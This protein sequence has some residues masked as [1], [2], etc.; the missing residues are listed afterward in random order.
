VDLGGGLQSR[1]AKQLKILSAPTAVAIHFVRRLKMGWNKYCDD[2][3]CPHF[4]GGN[5]NSE[6]CALGFILKFRTPKSYSDI[7]TCNW[8]WVMPK[9]CRRKYKN[10]VK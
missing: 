4:Q 10:T 9:A 2:V 7:M 8:G 5:I 1:R 6:D 3:D